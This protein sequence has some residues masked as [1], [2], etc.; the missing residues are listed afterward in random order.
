M[1]L[2][3]DTLL[4]DEGV[5]NLIKALD[6]LYLLKHRDY[7][8]YKA[9]ETFEKFKCSSSMT[10]NNYIIRWHASIQIFK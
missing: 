6:H 10:I 2:N 9:Y 4:V 7:S 1:E 5:E 3:S 8:A